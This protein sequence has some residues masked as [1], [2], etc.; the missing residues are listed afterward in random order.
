MQ[1][2][3][4]Q[5]SRTRNARELTLKVSEE[6]LRHATECPNQRL[7]Y[8]LK[9]D[10]DQLPDPS[11][12]RQTQRKSKARALLRELELIEQEFLADEEQIDLALIRLSLER[13]ELDLELRYND[14]T[15]AEQSPRAGK[16]IGNGISHLLMTDILSRSDKME[17]IQKRI[18][19]IPEYLNQAKAALTQPITPWKETET[20]QL[21]GLK[22]LFDVVEALSPEAAKA[23][24]KNRVRAEE[25]IAEYLQALNAKPLS[26]T[27]TIGRKQTQDILRTRGINESTQDLYALALDFEERHRASLQ[28]RQ[29]K[30]IEKHKLPKETGPQELLSWLNQHH[31]LASTAQQ[32]KDIIAHYRQEVERVCTYI[33]NVKLFPLT[34]TENIRIAETPDH[35]KPCIPAGA[36]VPPAPL[37]SKTPESI[38][39]LTLTKEQ[40][41]NHS[42]LSVPT[43]MIHECIPG[44]HLQLSWAALHPSKI[45]RIYDAAAHAEGWATMQE[46]YMLESGYAGDL[47][48]EAYFVMEIDRGRFAAR[49]CIDL[50]FM[51]GE[52]HYLDIGANSPNPCLTTFENAANLLRTLCGFN[53]E[54]IHGELNFYSRER[55]YPSAYLIGNHKAERLRE[56]CRRKM[57]SDIR[58]ADRFFHDTY[59]KS[60]NMSL[61]LLEKVFAKH[62]ETGS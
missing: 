47:S 36:M 2:H 9:T 50:F 34:N 60:G 45:R 26:Q 59:L 37:G 35:L 29:R 19:L 24:R 40:I 53:E 5:E 27:F 44:H 49:T 14:K 15:D 39:Y 52:H 16:D 30:L 4:N 18:A 38:V 23:G 55:G 22:A 6:Y 20:Q 54:R 43:M 17:V 56:Q 11:Q 7:F 8:G 48:D 32:P 58:E 57:Q 13:E 61:D 62:W 51:T 1:E 10:L 12:T 25:A 3:P 33:E 42:L 46:E 41:P 31:P 28:E 21:N